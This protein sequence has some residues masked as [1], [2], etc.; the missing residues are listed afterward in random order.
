MAWLGLSLLGPREARE[1]R[2]ILCSETAASGTRLCGPGRGGDQAGSRR[3][4]QAG[5]FVIAAAYSGK[6][7]EDDKRTFPR[8]WQSPSLRS[9]LPD[10][11]RLLIQPRAVTP[12]AQGGGMPSSPWGSVLPVGSYPLCSRPAGPALTSLREAWLGLPPVNS[13]T[14]RVQAGLSY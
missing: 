11:P 14:P 3:G 10:S 12:G 8:A 7:A 2:G 6:D 13:L 9:G 5:P 1:S 4:G